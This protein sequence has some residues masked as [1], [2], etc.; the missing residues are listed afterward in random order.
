MNGVLERID[1]LDR[2]VAEVSESYAELHQRVK[3]QEL[4]LSQFM[5]KLY[6]ETKL[7]DS[8]DERVRLEVPKIE[9]LINVANQYPKDLE[10]I[11]SVVG[12]SEKDIA[13]RL[14]IRNL[15]LDA[16][17]IIEELPPEA[18]LAVDVTEKRKSLEALEKLFEASD[19]YLKDS[20]EAATWL[21]KNR[22]N[23]VSFVRD[24]FF[25]ND[26]QVNGWDGLPINS[27]VVTNRQVIPIFCHDLDFYLMWIERH[28]RAGSTP[29][30]VRQG[31]ALILPRAVYIEA[32]KAIF[33]YVEREAVSNLSP[34]AMFRIRLYISRFLIKRDITLD[35]SH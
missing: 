24:S 21:G 16:D 7:A 23:L 4:L 14:L 30:K 15:I 28:L 2:N 5:K 6:P 13:L 20:I 19:Q 25:Q 3:S 9:E 12:R 18:E 17:R 34:G 31:A 22:N 35:I 27:L 29:E 26:G 10:D 11:S 8:L 32:F 33:K 1:K